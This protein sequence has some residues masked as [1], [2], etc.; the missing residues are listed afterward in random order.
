M[1]HR[2]AVADG[3]QHREHRFN[4]HASIPCPTL[5]DL[6]VGGIP[7]LRIETRIGQDA[8]G[9]V[10]LGN[11]GLKMRGVHIR[12]GA[13]DR[14]PSTAYRKY[15]ASLARGKWLFLCVI[16]FRAL[17]RD[18]RRAPLGFSN[19]TNS[20]RSTSPLIHLSSEVPRQERPCS[21]SHPSML[22]PKAPHTA[23]DRS[24]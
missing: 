19:F 10:T 3:G 7:G 9:V 2:L 17:L 4:Q 5:A 23:A 21:G 24:T 1:V 8:H 14:K 11:Q 12:R 6:H 22:Y 16:P 18:F 13:G 20:L 15:R